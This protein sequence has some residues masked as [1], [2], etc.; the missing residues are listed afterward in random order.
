MPKSQNE[1][2]FQFFNMKL[3]AIG[4]VPVLIAAVIILVFML[5]WAFK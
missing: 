5:I 2:H 1:I 3:S 4:L